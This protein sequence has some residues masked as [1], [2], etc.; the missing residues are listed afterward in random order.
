MENKAGKGNW[1][2]NGKLGMSL[3]GQMCFVG[4]R[5]SS[6]A[7]EQWCYVSTHVFKKQTLKGKGRKE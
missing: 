6:V 7:L 1:P 4:N 2:E 5:K 3:C